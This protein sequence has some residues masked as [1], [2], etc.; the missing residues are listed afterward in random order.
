MPHETRVVVAVL[1]MVIVLEY[2]SGGE[3]GRE[4]TWTSVGRRC[5]PVRFLG[6]KWQR[7]TCNQIQASVQIWYDVMRP[8]RGPKSCCS[9]RSS[10]VLNRI[11]CQF[12]AR[13]EGQSHSYDFAQTDHVRG[14][15]LSWIAPWRHVQFG[16]IF[17]MRTE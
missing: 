11:G 5:W 15:T 4:K 8:S 17:V 14:V 12:R 10:A 13:I 1:T 7:S 9:S 6:R 2:E 3:E 16:E